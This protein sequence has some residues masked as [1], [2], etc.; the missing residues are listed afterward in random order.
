MLLVVNRTIK[1]HECFWRCSLGISDDQ[2]EFQ[3]YDRLSFMRFL[4]FGFADKVPD[5]KVWLFRELHRRANTARS[6]GRSAIEHLFAAEKHRFRLFVRTIGIAR[7]TLKIG[8]VNL[9]YNFSRLV[10]LEGR[11]VPG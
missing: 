1:S 9:V 3:I 2:T 4:G 11:A 7:A 5:A 8:M 10:W 6:K